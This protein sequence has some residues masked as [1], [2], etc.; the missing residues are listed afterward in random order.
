MSSS[1]DD[2]LLAAEK[3]HDFFP[4]YEF[5]AVV[6][7]LFKQTGIQKSKHFQLKNHQSR[8]VYPRIILEKQL[9]NANEFSYL[10]IQKLPLSPQLTIP[11]YGLNGSPFYDIVITHADDDSQ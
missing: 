2:L 9:S 5:K 11:K 4:N 7:A 1:L 3:I 10:K 8:P 6:D